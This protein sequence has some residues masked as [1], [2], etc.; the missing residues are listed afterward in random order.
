MALIKSRKRKRKRNSNNAEPYVQP[1]ES[2]QH[3]NTISTQ[4]SQVVSDRSDSSDL[5]SQPEQNTL[6][7][8][9]SLLHLNLNLVQN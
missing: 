4:D 1:S 5:R 6:Q 3:T 9:V 2:E 8:T 7:Q